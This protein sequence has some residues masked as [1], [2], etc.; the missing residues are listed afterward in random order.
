MTFSFRGSGIGVRRVRASGAF[1][2][3]RPLAGGRL[4]GG[5]QVAGRPDDDLAQWQPE[6]D[7]HGAG[8]QAWA[9][10]SSAVWSGA[11][12]TRAVRATGYGAHRTRGRIPH[13]ASSYPD[14]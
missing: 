1:F 14:P 8:G 7:Q 4:R 10:V 12:Y 13:R 3:S 9:P 2:F 5:L 6:L 11:G